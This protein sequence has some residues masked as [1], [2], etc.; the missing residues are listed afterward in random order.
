[1]QNIRVHNMKKKYQITPHRFKIHTG[2]EAVSLKEVNIKRRI[3]VELL[4][5]SQTA[6]TCQKVCQ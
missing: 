5:A 3:F 4:Q 1:M 6:S 2:T